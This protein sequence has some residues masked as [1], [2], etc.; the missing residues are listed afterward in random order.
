MIA[1]NEPRAG[2][3]AEIF[4]GCAEVLA[5]WPTLRQALLTEHVRRPDGS[6]LACS[7]G[8]RSNTPWPCGP[9]SLAELA[10]RLAV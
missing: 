1:S 7:V 10:E 4:H 2:R 6:C 8:S 9:R 3:S 5:Q